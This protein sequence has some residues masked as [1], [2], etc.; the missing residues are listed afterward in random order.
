MVSAD[1]DLRSKPP[2]ST[3]EQVICVFLPSINFEGQVSELF[4]D[5]AELLNHTHNLDINEHKRVD[6][7]KHQKSIDTV[8]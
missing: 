3:F 5:L 2:P 1:L 6:G 4:L 8:P 7:P